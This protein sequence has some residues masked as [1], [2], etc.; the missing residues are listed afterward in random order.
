[1]YNKQPEQMWNRQ[2]NCAEAGL[3]SHRESVG[4]SAWLEALWFAW[5]QQQLSQLRLRWD[6]P[7]PGAAPPCECVCARLLGKQMQ[8]HLFLEVQAVV[9]WIWVE[10]VGGTSHGGGAEGQPFVRVRPGSLVV[11]GRPLLPLN[12]AVDLRLLALH[13]PLQQLQVKVLLPPPLGNANRTQ[14]AHKKEI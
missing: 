7:I 5:Q 12:A 2:S 10:L 13:G 9:Q 6:P 3:L 14:N 4:L 1:M 8:V 11:L